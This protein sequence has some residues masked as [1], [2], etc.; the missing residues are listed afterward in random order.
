MLK[1]SVFIPILKYA[2]LDAE[3]KVYHGEFDFQN[4]IRFHGTR[5]H[6]N[7]FT[8]IRKVQPY[9][10]QYSRISQILNCICADLLYWIHVESRYRNS[11]TPIMNMS[12]TGPIFTKFKNIQSRRWSYSAPSF[13]E[14][15]QEIWKLRQKTRNW[16]LGETGKEILTSYFVKIRQKP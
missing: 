6:L 9:L 1:M 3:H 7:W 8:S 10:C 11:F 12:F 2:L 13:T 5:L 14:I 15:G 4:V 16:R